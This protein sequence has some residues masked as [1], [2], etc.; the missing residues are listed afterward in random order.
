MAQSFSGFLRVPEPTGVREEM[1]THVLM[2][3]R[4]Q[5]NALPSLEVSAERKSLCDTLG[6]GTFAINQLDA[7]RPRHNGDCAVLNNL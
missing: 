2:T 1:H 7:C 3:T 4:P 5:A 6:C